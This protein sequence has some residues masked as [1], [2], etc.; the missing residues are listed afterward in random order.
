MYLLVE[1]GQEITSKV[2]Y[3]SG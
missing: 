3:T 1:Y 2:M